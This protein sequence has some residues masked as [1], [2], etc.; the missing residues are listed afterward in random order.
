MN[1]WLNCTAS[2]DD[3]RGLPNKY[4]IIRRTS[5]MVQPGPA[6]TLVFLDERADSINDAYFVI[7]M[8]PKGRDATLSNWPASYHDG[9][10]GVSFADGGA[11]SRRWLD[12][13]TNPAWKPGLYLGFPARQSPDNPDVEWLQN[14]ATGLK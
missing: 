14:H 13:R 11:A 10:G 12:P 1:S 6:E 9:A 7:F 4:R 2:P 3:Y 5:D 8:N